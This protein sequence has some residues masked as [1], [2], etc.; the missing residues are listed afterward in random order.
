MEYKTKALSQTIFIY[1]RFL[2]LHPAESY[3]PPH[4][5]FSLSTPWT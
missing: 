1:F 2:A 4:V 3:T 5:T